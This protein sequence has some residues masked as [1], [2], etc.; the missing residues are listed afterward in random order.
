MKVLRKLDLA[1]REKVLDLINVATIHDGIPPIADHVLLHLRHGGDRADTHILFEDSGPL[2]GYAH[3]DTTDEV[4]GPSAELFIHP[5][6]RKQSYGRQLLSHIRDIAGPRLRLWSHG[7][8]P[9]AQTLATHSGFFRVR[10][11][12]H[13]QMALS[14]VPQPRATT[15]IRNFLPGIDNAEWLALNN[16]IFKNH[17][18]QGQ[19]RIQDLEI[20]I[21]EDWFDPQGFL[22]ATDNEKIMGFCWTK[23][24]GG[25]SHNHGHDQPDHDHEALGE[26]YSM[27]V[28]PAYAQRGIGRDITLAGLHYLRYR[29]VHSAILYV[30]E[31]N[32]SARNLYQS[33][34][35]YESGRDVLYR[36]SGH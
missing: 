29:G 8:L 33:I 28:A 14:D 10:T 25:H 23:I 22:L 7:D 20:R 19:W 21:A 13:M 18:E 16:A 27:G 9:G 34:G 6:Y 26:I 31:L 11:V 17:P 30:D 3:L 24:H 5:H 1:S 12:I 4:E 35:F 36:L 15:S 32:N 2:V